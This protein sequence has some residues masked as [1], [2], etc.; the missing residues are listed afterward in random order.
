MKVKDKGRAVILDGKQSV[1]LPAFSAEILQECKSSKNRKCISNEM[2]PVR[3]RNGKG[4]HILP[5]LKKLIEERENWKELSEDNKENYQFPGSHDSVSGNV[6]YHTPDISK[7]PHYSDTEPHFLWSD[8]QLSKS[9]TSKNKFDVKVE[10]KMEELVYWISQCKGVKKCSGCDHVVPNSYIKNN[11]TSHPNAELIQVK[12]CPVEFV[13]IFPVNCMSD[14]RRWS[15]GI[16]RS[17]DVTKEKNLHNHPVRQS[18]S[19]KLPKRLKS[20]IT[21]TVEDNP[22]LKTRQLASG[23]GL[24]YR[25]D[26]SANS[27][28]RLDYQRK[29]ALKESG[30]TVK[31][32]TVIAEMEAIADKIDKKDCEVEGS[33]SMS[34]RYAKLGRPYMRDY[35]ISP[36]FTYQFI[37]SPLMTKLLS[38]AEFL[39]TDTTYNE[40]CELIYLFNAAVFD[41][42]T[43]KWAVVA[44]MRANK[45]NADLYKKT[46]ELMFKFC[47]KDHPNFKVGKTLKGIIVDWSD[48][49]AKGLR[50]VIGDELAGKVLRGCNVHWSRSWL[51]E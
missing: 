29:R 2:N 5:I 16:I 25:P 7:L 36:T 10:S 50:E 4:K 22:Y 19:H 6:L 44:R 13:Y 28:G 12:N 32:V 20:D 18:L 15:G 8:I 1:L 51:K 33:V 39:E 37:M 14:H 24:G 38:E 27:Y 42:T 17:V 47:H 43:M 48:T 26:V 21:R 9:S 35:G 11:C 31:G 49:E 46:F 34:D 41:Y 40:N 45:E 3:K 23:H 30:L